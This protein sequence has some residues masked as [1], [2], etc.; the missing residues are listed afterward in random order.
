MTDETGLIVALDVPTKR[1]AFRLLNTIDRPGCFVKVGMELYFQTGPDIVRELKA[2]G[3]SVFLDL[4]V[5]DIPHTVYRT[6]KGLARAGADMVDVHAAG[7]AEMMRAAVSG[8]AEGATDKRPLCL[9]VTQLTSTDQRMLEEELLIRTPIEDVV[10]SYASLACRSGIDGVVCSA[11]EV[12]RIKAATSSTFLAVTP[13]IRLERDA[14]G[15]QKR[16]ATPGTA[17]AFGSDY[18]V[19]GRSIT[20]AA[21][22]HAAYE[23]ILEQWRRTDD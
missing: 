21:D 9:A 3:C 8:L 18:I 7:G 5:H 22:P 6:M 13:G 14:A 20:A 23:Q 15:D 4:K 2:R 16:I 11:S 1:E 19:V 12:R 17:R 10:A